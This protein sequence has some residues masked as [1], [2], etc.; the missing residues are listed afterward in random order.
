MQR[1]RTSNRE[2]SSLELSAKQAGVYP[3]EARHKTNHRSGRFPRETN[4][5]Q[6]GDGSK[7]YEDPSRE[8]LKVPLALGTDSSQKHD[9]AA[10]VSQRDSQNLRRTSG[11]VQVAKQNIRIIQRTSRMYRAAATK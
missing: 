9:L 8:H 6:F 3:I 4:P 2:A 10:R 1:A 11:N 7:Q 5:Q